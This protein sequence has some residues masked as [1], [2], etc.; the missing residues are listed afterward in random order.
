MPIIRR[1]CNANISASVQAQVFAHLISQPRIERANPLG[2]LLQ[3]KKYVIAVKDLLK[4]RTFCY[5]K[6]ICD[7]SFFIMNLICF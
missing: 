2:S 4:L 7:C 1:R 6:I 3:L 5:L